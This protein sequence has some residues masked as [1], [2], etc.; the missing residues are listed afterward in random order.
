MAMCFPA[1]T[2]T[3]KGDEL[4]LS[5]YTQYWS[6][7]EKLIATCLVCSDKTAAAYAAEIWIKGVQ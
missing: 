1:L 5:H 2:K 3:N 7:T 4:F 6:E